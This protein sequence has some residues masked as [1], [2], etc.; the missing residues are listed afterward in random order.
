MGEV[1]LR[2][3]ELNILVRTLKVL[4]ADIILDYEQLLAMQLNNLSR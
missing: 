2:E 3:R 4:S 1:F